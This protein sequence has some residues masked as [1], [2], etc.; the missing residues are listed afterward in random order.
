MI[1]YYYYYIIIIIIIIIIINRPYC[2]LV[3]TS[4]KQKPQ[5]Q[6]YSSSLACVYVQKLIKKLKSSYNNG[7]G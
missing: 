1:I 5:P 7:C 2:N 3:I 4:H 6:S